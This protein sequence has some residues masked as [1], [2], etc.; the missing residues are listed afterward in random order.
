MAGVEDRCSWSLLG[1]R[2][3]ALSTQL[4]SRFVVLLSLRV[5]AKYRVERQP[6]F[7]AGQGREHG[8][9]RGVDDSYENN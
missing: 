5:R 1:G 3:A 9:L 2:N 7:L 8:E 4:S 6:W